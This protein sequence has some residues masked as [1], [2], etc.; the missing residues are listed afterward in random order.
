MLVCVV[1][2]CCGFDACVCR[3]CALLCDV[4][5]VVRWWLCDYLCLCAKLDVCA[6]CDVLCDVVWCFFCN[7][8]LF[9]CGC[10]VV[11]LCVC[12]LCL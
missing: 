3:A 7:V 4:A 1:V 12:V 8:L 2:C 9:A 11:V 6:V 10:V 5:S